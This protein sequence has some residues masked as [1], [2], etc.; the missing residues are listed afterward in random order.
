MKGAIRG[1]GTQIT[2]TP[3]PTIFP[4]TDFEPKTIILTKIQIYG[5]KQKPNESLED[6]EE[7]FLAM[8]KQISRAGVGLMG[9]DLAILKMMKVPEDKTLKK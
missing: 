2:F 7:H 9:F 4:K 5:L 1:S 8:V 6:F 3:D